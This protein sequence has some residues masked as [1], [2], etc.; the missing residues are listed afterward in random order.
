MNW[1]RTSPYSGQSGDWAIAG[2]EAW[3][4]PFPFGLHW[5]GRLLRC[6]PCKDSAKSAARLLQGAVTAWK[7]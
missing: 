4:V 3:N 7:L 5:R 2:S 1:Q 6:F